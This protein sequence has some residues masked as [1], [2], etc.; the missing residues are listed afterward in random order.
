MPRPRSRTDSAR[1]P[2]T[3]EGIDAHDR[4][5]YFLSGEVLERDALRIDHLLADDRALDI[6]QDLA[7]KFLPPEACAVVS[8]VHGADI[9]GGKVRLVVVH[10]GA[11]HDAIVSLGEVGDQAA[12]L[13]GRCADD[14][15][16]GARSDTLLAE[17]KRLFRR[18]PLGL[19]GV[20]LIEPR[21]V[22]CGASE[23][24]GPLRGEE[25]DLR[26][27]VR[28]Q[29]RIILRCPKGRSL[30]LGPCAHQT[31]CLGGAANHRPHRVA[32]GRASDVDSASLARV[33]PLPHHLSARECLTRA[34]TPLENPD[35]PVAVGFDLVR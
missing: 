12:P 31:G 32:P 19:P 15:R 1:V 20:D 6:G 25:L 29:K 26:A 24:L 4:S 30:M 23:A 22:G 3:P 34:R 5:I 18:H 7:E 13:R 33:A 16:T 9:R 14:L 35:E 2:T 27:V 8:A 17:H 11:G 10:R 28:E 21:L